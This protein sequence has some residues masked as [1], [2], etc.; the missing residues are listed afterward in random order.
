MHV[1]SIVAPPGH[2]RLPALAAEAL[3]QDITLDFNLPDLRDDYIKWLNSTPGGKRTFAL[4]QVGETYYAS[5][6][7][8]YLWEEMPLDYRIQTMTLAA[9]T[10]M[11]GL[12][13]RASDI[14]RRHHDR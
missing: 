12:A 9:Q 10:H 5:R 14:L 11:A 1:L 4:L 3:G 8:R 13:C 2:G 7:L 6:E